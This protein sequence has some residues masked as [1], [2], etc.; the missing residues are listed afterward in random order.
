VGKTTLIHYLAKLIRLNQGA[1]Y[2]GGKRV[3]LWDLGRMVS[4]AAAEGKDIENE[5]RTAFQEA[6]FAGNVILVIKDIK[7]YLGREEASYHPDITPVIS[8]Y[9]HYPSFQVLA[10]S[11]VKD[12]HRLVEKQ[13]GFMKFFETVEMKEPAKSETVEILLDNFKD[14]ER[15]NVIFTYKALQRVVDSSEKYRWDVPL[16]E[17]AIDLAQEVLVFWQSQGSSPLITPRLVDDFAT[18]KTGAPQGEIRKGEQETLLKLEKILHQRIIGQNEA[19]CQVA[20][21]LRR[22]RSGTGDPKKPI[23]AFLFLGPTGVGKTETAKA[24]AEAYFSDEEKMIRLD[25]SEFQTPHSIDRLVGSTVSGQPGQLVSLAKD[26]PFSLL[27]LDE[28]E[29]ADGQVLDPFSSGFGRGLSD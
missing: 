27:L 3:L 26:H 7:N 24:L 4:E 8:E 13:E 1:G 23:G 17:R 28:L 6:A 10:T 18:L 12:Y 14:Y 15:K 9:L 29:K 16:P 25:M 2:L 5:L 22:A 20:E 21:A 11:T 19:I